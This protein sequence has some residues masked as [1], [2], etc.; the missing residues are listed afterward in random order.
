[1]RFGKRSVLLVFFSVFILLLV[2]FVQTVDAGYCANP[3]ERDYYCIEADTSYC[4]PTS[5]DYYGVNGAP[6]DQTD[7]KSNYYD[8]T[9]DA[10][11]GGLCSVGCCYYGTDVTCDSSSTEPECVFNDGIFDGKGCEGSSV[12]S[13]CE[14]GC[15]V[16]DDGTGTTT[17]VVS[18]YGYCDVLI[19]NGIDASFANGISD[20]SSCSD[21]A[22]EYIVGTYE[23]FD[24]IDNDGDGAKDYPADAGC[25][26]Y[27]DSSEEAV[28][29]ACSDGEDND[30]DGFIDIEDT[31]CCGSEDTA[32]EQLC[33]VS[34]CGDGKIASACN[35]Y[36][37]GQ[38]E[39]EGT[40]CSA[41]NYCVNGVC[42]SEPDDAECSPGKRGFCGTSDVNG[43][44]CLM[45]QTCQSDYTWSSCELDYFSC[46]KE[47][48]VCTDNVDN[49][50]DALVDCQDIDCY[51]TYCGSS[52][53]ACD[54]YGFAP[55]EDG[56]FVCCA[57]TDVKD[58]DNDG[59]YETCGTCDCFTTPIIPKIEYIEFTLGSAQLTVSWDLACAVQFSLL[60]CTGNECVN[61]IE[62]TDTASIEASF[63]EI[64]TTNTNAWEFTDTNVE[65][66][67][68]YC[69]IVK[70][71]YSDYGGDDTY[72]EPICI[73]DSGDYWCQQL[74]TSEFCL[75]SNL[76]MSDSLRYRYGCTENNQLSL[77]EQCSSSGADYICVGPYDDGTTACVYQS[78][79][80]SC[81]DPLGLYALFDYS[82]MLNNNDKDY[83]A[84]CYQLPMCYFDYTKTTINNFHE[85]AEITSC[86]DYASKSACEGQESDTS[87]TN[88]C[89][90]RNCAWEYLSG[91]S[92]SN[93]PNGI[94]K[95]LNA[96]YAQCSA[97]NDVSHNGVFDTCTT[98]RCQEFSVDEASCYLSSLTKTCT[99]IADFTCTAYSDSGSCNGGVSKIVLDE[100]TNEI[101]TASKDA[102]DLGVCYWDGENCFKD[103]NADQEM[104]DQQVDMDPPKTSV[105]SSSKMKSIDIMLLSKD[106]N[107]DGSKG[108][109]VKAVYYC[110]DDGSGC[111]LDRENP[112]NDDYEKITLESNGLGTIAAGDG[113]GAYTLYYYAEDYAENLEVVN[114]WDFEVDKNG[115]EIVIL[116]YVSADT[117]KPYDESALTFEVSLDEEAYCV[118][119]FDG[120]SGY[121][122]NQYNDH[123]VVKFEDLTDGW[124]VYSVTCM[125]AIGNSA[126]VFVFANIDADTAIFDT[127]PAQYTDS[128]AVT[129]SIKTFEPAECGFSYNKEEADFTDMDYG[130]S[131][132]NL[133]TYY[134]HS[135]EWTLDK[136][137]GLYYFDVKCQFDDGTIADDEIQFIYDDAAPSTDVVDSYGNAFDFAAYYQG[138]DIDV[139]LACT[140][141]PEYGFGCRTTYY[142]TDINLCEPDTLYEKT[143]SIAYNG[144]VDSFYVCYYSIEDTF[145]GMGG[146]TEGR[147]CTELTIDYYS[148][149][150]T[151]TGPKDKEIVYVPYVTIEGTIKDPDAT[152]TTAINSVKIILV[153]TEGDEIVY[154]NIDASNG[155]FSY[156][157]EGLTLET[158]SSAYNKIYITASDRSGAQDESQID[159]LYT[160]D[161]EG[162]VIWIEEPSNGVSDGASFN[163]VVGT[164]LEAEVCGYSKTTGISFE[165][166][167]ALEPKVSDTSGEYFY[168]AHY[169]I[170]ENKNGIPEYVYVTCELVNGIQYSTKFTLEYDSTA[171]MIEDI[172]LVNSDGKEPPTVIEKPLDPIIDVKTDDPTL[173]K[174]SFDSSS[175]FSTGMKKF[176]NFD[177][178]K[179]NTT[180]NMTITGLADKTSYT[181]YIACQNG[182]YAVS[183]TEYLDFTIDSTAA[184]GMYL[185]DPSATGSRT[186]S[187]LLGT[188]RTASSCLYGVSED[189]I[190]LPMTDNGSQK[191]WKSNSITVTEDG[192]YTYY[193][194]CWFVDGE[195]NDYF[196][197]IVDTSGPKID[198][199][200]DGNVSYSSTQLS[201]QWSAT[202]DLTEIVNYKYSIGSRAGYVDISNW[203]ETTDTET[204]VENL[205]LTNQS[206]YYWNVVAYNEVD[207]ASTVESSDGVFID[208]NGNGANPNLNEK[209]VNDVD[210]HVCSNDIIDEGETDIDCG[211][212][213]D[214]CADGFACGT[215][216]DCISINCDDGICQQATCFD[217][218]KNQG[219]SDVDCG[220]NYCEPCGEGYSCTYHRDCS[221][222][223]C[224]GKIC[225]A[226]SCYDGAKNGNEE[227]IDC[228]GEC[229]DL[230]ETVV[231]QKN[232]S[233]HL[234]EEEKQGIGLVGW[235]AILLIVTGLGLGGYYSY[236]YYTRKKLSAKGLGLSGLPSLSKGMPPLRK[237]ATP[238]LAKQ[239]MQQMQQARQHT[240]LEKQT[241]R[242]KLFSAFEEKKTSEKLPTK[243]DGQKIV[244]AKKIVTHKKRISKPAESSDT[245]RKLDE[246][247]KKKKK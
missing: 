169:T 206:T 101:T 4:C 79:C 68:R 143:D 97:C 48:E 230:C 117:S 241:Q 60:R 204:I 36:G 24:G 106:Y 193:F 224:E 180:N 95:E 182:A 215:D 176:S 43:I 125:D 177:E 82:T 217:Y 179:Y 168:G 34:T 161:I 10:T 113:K 67:Q 65:A 6:R 148:P 219:E 22:A 66:N 118:D 7:C 49:D 207:L 75:D 1:M 33:E 127:E 232:P 105:L 130:F 159:V 174:Y 163:F 226:P 211:G 238:S 85:C 31:G 233:T 198:Y 140:D 227:G 210:Y 171:P 141:Q 84:M 239:Q 156:T 103:A 108:S 205:N 45:Y 145:A 134:L 58:C 200:E 194:N 74:R 89:L 192:I 96:E 8:N 186:F 72:S 23:C 11:V 116:S 25:S 107:T 47:P 19:E 147:Q 121:I 44:T 26:D 243:N 162:D 172:H 63:A 237:S 137:N 109:G 3:G 189:S 21:L 229:P 191:Q 203:T 214:A 54:D 83:G 202:D 100:Q 69:Y 20:Y 196:T 149:S 16:Y 155:T 98:E 115:P 242:S 240:A 73:D 245:F 135:E 165:K 178:G 231:L 87:F 151:I 14:K 53:E 35:C 12:I 236:V 124:Y 15:C 61:S 71:E 138:E 27:A 190:N 235:M 56:N 99:D 142:C 111:I 41:G 152:S 77:I 39:S 51:R 154:D 212:S 86:Y 150:L 244:P 213:C 139:Y 52:A 208:A 90:Q 59:D 94:C 112:D 132:S 246:L 28:G 62:N 199:I 5:T 209:E 122:N 225:T 29:S 92:D 110:I 102:L 153:T 50:G 76:E 185:I 40:Y 104:D 32:H 123:F 57:T 78:D 64:I 201:A 228:G 30:G 220:G 91:E 144:D 131:S 173:C 170:S 216:N 9:G 158:N 218:I 80:E 17:S 81:G 184:S 70:A 13:Y 126:D 181:I 129:L 195:V 188:T 88:K 93:I 164:F 247:I 136:G 197:T 187:L 18:S 133:G 183:D 160:N 222:G 146:L 175:G 119:S 55:E 223:Y 166:Y 2:S 234:D 120:N 38:D 157:V 37:E 46:G 114:L 221:S 167:I 42:Q 128:D